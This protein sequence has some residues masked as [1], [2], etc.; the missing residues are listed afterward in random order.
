[1]LALGMVVLL[2]SMMLVMSLNH[3]RISRTV[4]QADQILVYEQI[5]EIALS[6]LVSGI[7]TGEITE[8]GLYQLLPEDIAGYRVFPIRAFFAD[9]AGPHRFDITIESPHDPHARDRVRSV[10]IQCNNDFCKIDRVVDK[11]NRS[12][13]TFQEARHEQ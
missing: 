9:S 10:Y 1:M 12:S 5:F 11:N 7:E 2:L 13:D 3:Q 8:S 6:K 4:R